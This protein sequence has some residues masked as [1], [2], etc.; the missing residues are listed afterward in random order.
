MSAI[1]HLQKA[2][3]LP[4]IPVVQPKEAVPQDQAYSAECVM[5][6]SGPCNGLS[7]EEAKKKVVEIL[8]QQGC[9]HRAIQYK[10]RDWLFSRQRYLVRTD[11]DFMDRA[12]WIS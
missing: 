2:F 8:E 5:I 12:Y 4:I 6:N 7:N 1:T 11:S 3:Q 9:G 10:L